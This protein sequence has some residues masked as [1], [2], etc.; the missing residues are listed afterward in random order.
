MLGVRPWKEGTGWLEERAALMTLPGLE[1]CGHRY[2]TG[3]VRWWVV[4]AL[5]QFRVLPVE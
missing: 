2:G 1:P 3:R 5:R 4:Y